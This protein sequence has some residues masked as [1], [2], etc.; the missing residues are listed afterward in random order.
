M[1]TNRFPDHMKDNCRRITSAL[2]Y[3]LVVTGLICWSACPSEANAQGR[4]A[5]A[6]AAGGWVILRDD[7]KVVTFRDPSNWHDP[8]VVKGLA[9]VVAILWS[10]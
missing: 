3:G 7:G 4:R 1:R 6:I 5:V 2:S 9:D 8:V 10:S